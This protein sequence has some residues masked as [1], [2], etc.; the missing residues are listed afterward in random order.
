[1]NKRQAIFWT[2]VEIIHS[3]I[4]VSL[5]LNELNEVEYRIL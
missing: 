5:G 1:M 2:N 4:C 3:H